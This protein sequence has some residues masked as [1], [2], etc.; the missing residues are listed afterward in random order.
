MKKRMTMKTMVMPLAMRWERLACAKPGVNISSDQSAMGKVSRIDRPMLRG[1]RAGRTLVAICT[2][3]DQ[4]RETRIKVVES[5][6][7]HGHAR[8][9]GHGFVAAHPAQ[10][11]EG[12]EPD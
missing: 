1:S 4:G 7:R 5:D 11:R 12:H 8:H 3:P 10:P 9:G 6:Q 2:L